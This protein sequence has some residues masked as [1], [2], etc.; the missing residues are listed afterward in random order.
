MT[1]DERSPLLSESTPSTASIQDATGPRKSIPKSQIIVLL[2]LALSEPV[3]NTLIEETGITKGNYGRVGYYAGII[4]SS[5]FV[6]EALMI[7][8]WG[9]LSDKIAASMLSFGLSTSFWALVVSRSLA[10]ALC[11]NV[12]VVKSSMAEMCDESNLAEAAA[13][14]PIVWP[15]GS[16]IGPLIGGALSHPFERYPNIFG[17]NHF[18]KKFP[19]FLPCATAAGYALSSAT[20]AFFAFKET[21]L[22]KTN[23]ASARNNSSQCHSSPLYPL[24]L[25]TP[26]YLGGLGFDPATI[27]ICLAATGLV[28]GV[29][30]FMF[31]GAIQRRFGTITVYRIGL[32]TFCVLFGLCPILNLLVRRNGGTMNGFAWALLVVQLSAQIIVSLTWGCIFMLITSSAPSSSALGTV[33]GMAQTSA[34]IA[35][36]IGP[37]TATGLFARSIQKRL[38]G[39]N[40]VYLILSIL[41]V[42]AL[43]DEKVSRVEEEEED[44]RG[45]L[46]SSSDA[47]RKQI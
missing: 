16:T 33:N 14:M 40:L 46:C 34:S 12:G 26:P 23:C 28:N 41:V 31:F 42:L 11:G 19:Y 17:G 6:A 38:L 7:L 3:T 13:F 30:Q 29:F 18:W 27:G 44:G 36:A 45:S 5:F 22:T 4:E 21:L 1:V 47:R 10:G 37:E 20:L 9:R 2:A 39:G 35:R 15:V 24:F 25:S 43:E 32:A 8:Q